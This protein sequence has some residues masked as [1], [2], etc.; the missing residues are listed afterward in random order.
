MIEKTADLPLLEDEDKKITMELL[1]TVIAPH[2]NLIQLF[3][4]SLH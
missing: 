4:F 1:F 3:M 2:F